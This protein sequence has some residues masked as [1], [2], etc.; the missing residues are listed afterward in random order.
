MKLL[1]ENLHSRIST[2]S[3]RGSPDILSLSLPSPLFF[4]LFL[5]DGLIRYSHA[6]LFAEGYTFV[7]I[8]HVRDAGR[9]FYAN[10]YHFA[11]RRRPAGVF[12]ALECAPLIFSPLRTTCS[13]RQLPFLAVYDTSIRARGRRSSRRATRHSS[14][15][16]QEVPYVRA[17]L[18][19][20]SA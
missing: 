7:R 18:R 20:A 6:I 5:R 8:G 12:S 9:R 15:R 2:G 4:S 11:S 10:V 13:L 1:R 16:G 17:S 3:V 14:R 19:A